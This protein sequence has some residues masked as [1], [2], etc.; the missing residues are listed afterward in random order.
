MTNET[1][2]MALLQEVARGTEMGK[3]TLEQMLP[4]TEDRLL[5]A[6]LLEE[7]RGYR[8]LNQ[9]AHTAI[10]ALGGEA[11]GAGSLEKLGAKMGILSRTLGGR[12]TQKLAQMLVEGTSAGI[13]A[14][15]QAQ[16]S[17]RTPAR[18]QGSSRTSCWNSSGRTCKAWN[19]FCEAAPLASPRGEGFFDVSAFLRGEKTPAPDA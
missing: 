11:E 6:E 12:S 7:Q 5:R 2:N 19:A 10:A 3:N 17:A 16:N 1:E 18:A 13:T 4:L 14:C 15:V 8:S 9:R